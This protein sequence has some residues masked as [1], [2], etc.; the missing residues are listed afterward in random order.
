M[1]FA[2]WLGDAEVARIGLGTNRLTNTGEH[3]AFVKEAVAD[4]MLKILIVCA[5]IALTLGI[6]VGEASELIDGIAIAKP[7]PYT[8]IGTTAHGID[9][10]I[11]KA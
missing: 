8:M 2:G 6:V 5:V 9:G 3:V 7:M 4:P 1:R 11:E 10:G